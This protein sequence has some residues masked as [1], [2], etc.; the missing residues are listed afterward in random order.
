[1]LGLAAATA[2]SATEAA[3]AADP[4]SATS[5]A[6]TDAD[7]DAAGT[8]ITGVGE[9]VVTARHRT[10]DA[11]K[12]PTALS[13]VSGAFLTKTNTTNIAQVAE[14]IPSLQF[15]FFNP[16][17]ANLNIR[18]LGNNIG[19]ANDGIEPGVG[20]Y[21]DG[22]YY[23]RPATATLDLIDIAQIEV[24]RGPQ[25]TLF[26][27]NTTAGAINVTTASPTFTP[28]FN[29]EVTGGDY[30]Y[31][32]A[33]GSVSGPIVGDTLAGRFSIATT[34]RA[35]Y[36]TN[37]HDNESVNNYRNLTLRGQILYTPTSNFR[38]RVIADYSKQ[39]TNCCDLSLAGIVNPPN[40]KN[41]AAYSEHFGY[42][43]VVNPF[44]YNVDS[45]SPIFAKQETGGVSAEADWSRPN[46]VLTSITAWRFWNWWPAN[47]SDYS[48]LSI[49]TLSQNGDRQ[50]Q[51]SQEFRVASAGHNRIDYVGGLYVFHEQIDATGAEQ[52]GAQ[53]SYFL[54][55]PLIPAV[56]ANGFTQDFTA[57]YDTTSL[58][59]FGQATWH[60][61]SRLNFIGG[62]R[63][64]YDIKS[65]RFDQTVSGGV[66]LTGPLAP[67]AP[68]R[69]ALSAPDAFSVNYDN[70][71]ISGQAGVSYQA[72]DNAL[73]YV[74][75]AR[76]NKSGGLNLTQLPVGATEVVAPESIDSV[77]VGA[78]T[79]FFDRR[80]TLNGDLFWEQDENYQANLVLPGT[81]H[82]YLA[83]VPLVRSE[84]VEA[85]LQA[86]PTENL[87]LYAAGTYDDAVYVS[88]KNAPC[89]LELITATTC[90]LSGRPLGGV[91]RWAASAGGEYSHPVTLGSREVKAY[92]GLDYTF[93]SSEYTSA[94]DSVYSLLPS[95]NLVNARV[96]V[97]AADGQW[98]LYLWGRNVFD[99]KYF[100]FIAAGVGNT[101]QLVGQVGDPP[102]YGVTLRVHY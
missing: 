51:F 39:V 2:F 80:L 94:N 69:A 46:V 35:G 10:E 82:Q 11:Q 100:T 24:L 78:K 87:L 49:L 58:A 34:S 99:A 19:L 40:G 86:Q 95:L 45:N 62:L 28:E 6:S 22:V 90:N 27:K 9:V 72:A 32:Q 47:D 64:T 1:M 97:R 84:G 74:T 12:V 21:V 56:V 29:G 89:P 81:V 70:G 79:Q 61:T 101:G 7:A 50:N 60:L 102:T 41:F 44:S 15:T 96:G 36:F 8:T 98:D 4:A 71:D 55:S 48:P 42:T 16:R 68:Y 14:L 54:L 18:G 59:A 75:Y 77:E 33:K 20:F 63:Y 53:A 66:P 25:G 73:A 88:Y 83:N 43:P 93:R 52:F 26:G 13:V 31:F 76:G 65:G 30:S 38:L 37:V 5:S 85:D 92:A 57:N 3:W 91:P 17:N 67:Y 23:D